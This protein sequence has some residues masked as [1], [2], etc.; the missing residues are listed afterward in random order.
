M[1]NAFA[2][3]AAVVASRYARRCSWCDR[4][5]LEQVAWEAMLSALP[6]YDEARPLNVY[7]FVVA[8]QAV[9]H[10]AWRSGSPLDV[11][12]RNSGDLPG[13]VRR[14]QHALIPVED[15]ADVIN[16]P[17]AASPASAV[18]DRDLRRQVAERCAALLASDLERDLVEQVLVGDGST[19]AVARA[20]SIS[21]RT[22][23]SRLAA[24]RD[25]LSADARLS[26]LFV[27]LA[28]Q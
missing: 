24:L 9:H 25:R 21:R 5:E 4:A 17:G 15:E 28:D 22:V 20:H 10:F 27:A 26:A 13:L 7:L 8:R 1:P 3:I 19:A 14:T 18:S 11:T 23:Q 16:D 12:T 6:R 2:S